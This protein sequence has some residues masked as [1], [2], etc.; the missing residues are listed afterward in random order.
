MWKC[1]PIYNFQLCPH[2]HTTFHMVSI[3]Q[4]YTSLYILSGN[5]VAGAAYKVVEAYIN[6]V[7]TTLHRFSSKVSIV[8]TCTSGWWHCVYIYLGLVVLCVHVPQVGSIVCTCQ[9]LGLVVLCVH[10]PQVGGI[11]CTCTSGW[12]YCVYMYLGLVVL[13][14][15]V[16]QVGSIVCT[17]TSGW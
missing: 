2:L 8:R 12:W 7:A 16:P 9:Y 11:V 10:V 17:C 3:L 6:I 14:V 4:G 1:Y 5:T 13:C 15:H